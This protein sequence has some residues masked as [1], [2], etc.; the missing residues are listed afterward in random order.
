MG[1][2][3]LAVAGLL[4]ACGGSSTTQ[5]LD[6]RRTTDGGFATETSPADVSIDMSFDLP[7]LVVPDGPAKPLIDTMQD[8]WTE[9]PLDASR[10]NLA[11]SP[12]DATQDGPF[13]STTDAWQAHGSDLVSERPKFE[14]LAVW[15]GGSEVTSATANKALGSNVSGLVY[16]PARTSTKAI[17]WAVQNDPSKVYRLIANGAQFLPDTTEG[18]GKGKT[19]LY[20]DG[21]GSPDSE[22][23]T[24]TE[25]DQVELYVVTERN[26][27]QDKKSRMSILRYELTGTATALKATQEWNLTTFLPSSDPNQGLEA[28]AWIPDSY[29]VTLGFFDEH[30]NVVYDPAKYPNHGTGLFLVGMET[31]GMIYGFILDHLTNSVIRVSQFKSGQANLMDLSFDRDTESLWT[32]C[33]DACENRITVLGIDSEVGSPTK[34]RFIVR[35]SLPPPRPIAKLNNE[36]LTLAPASECVDNHKRI[37]WSDDDESNGIAIRQGTLPC[38]RLF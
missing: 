36:G 19:L 25:W 5:T 22:G 34:G 14:A 6:T 27:D 12:L 8:R 16:Q 13:D 37:F 15:P 18:W 26:N 10:D 31:T 28:I 35:L 17:L 38:G 21:T 1:M 9:P 29:L 32:L 7:L 20:P 2:R 11:D 3:F 33:D 24:R 23:M 4:V 30:R